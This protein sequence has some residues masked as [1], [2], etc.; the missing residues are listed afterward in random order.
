MAV[1]TGL[2]WH[3]GD[4]LIHYALRGEGAARRQR[5]KDSVPSKKRM[6][7]QSFASQRL[8]IFNLLSAAFFARCNSNSCWMEQWRKNTHVGFYAVTGNWVVKQRLG[9]PPFLETVWGTLGLRGTSGIEGG[10]V[11]FTFQPLLQMQPAYINRQ[12]LEDFAPISLS[13]LLYSST[14]MNSRYPTREA[15]AEE[16]SN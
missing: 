3:D 6:L 15:V 1:W 7:L 9:T 12:S 14:S 4:Q 5:R 16:Q 13:M 2:R 10:N 8:C 11:L